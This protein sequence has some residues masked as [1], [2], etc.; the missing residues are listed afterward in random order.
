MTRT[1]RWSDAA[2]ADFGDQIDYI[3]AHNPKAARRVAGA[4]DEL[5]MALGDMPT[6]CPGRVTGTYEKLVVGLPYILA[7]AVLGETLVIL[8]VVHTSR[9]WPAELWPGRD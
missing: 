2:L 6:G 7:Y 1:V 8:R 3:A 5:A 4:I 9:D